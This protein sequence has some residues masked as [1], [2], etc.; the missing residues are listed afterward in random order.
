MMNWL[1]PAKKR[2]IP[3]KRWISIISRTV[4]LIGV[5]GLAGA[6]LYQQPVASWQWFLYLTVMSGFVMS[7]LEVYSDGIWLLQLRGTAIGVKLLLLSTMIWWFD[8]P[9]AIIYFL[10][11]IISGVVSHAPGK[12]RYFS[13]WHGRVIMESPMGKRHPLND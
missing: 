9:N 5:S 1:F 12:L 13:I 8:Q 10:A 11:I 6:Y 3:A 4:H 2:S 7:A